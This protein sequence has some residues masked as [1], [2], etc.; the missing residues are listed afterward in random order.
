MKY[1][2]FLIM[3]LSELVL[4]DGSKMGSQSIKSTSKSNAEILAAREGAPVHI[5]A[6]ASFLIWKDSQYILKVK[7]SNEFSC[8][9]W[10]DN[11]GTFE[12]SCINEAAKKSVLP[13]YQ[14]QRQMLE[15]NIPIQKIHEEIAHK[16]KTGEFPSP[17]PGAVVYMMSK[18][19]KFYD[20]FG[21]KLMDIEP[22]V[23]L[24][25]PK[26]NANSLE[27]NGKDGLPHFYSDFPHLSVI[28]LHTTAHH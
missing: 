2:I 10:A 25:Y 13:A 26:I 9:I 11:K 16:A 20:H 5:S 6:N 1:I 14:F 22:H 27:F 12:P 3:G 24:Y 23:M 4:A 7:G 21:E 8:F 17:A 19:N 18:R 28:H 15:K